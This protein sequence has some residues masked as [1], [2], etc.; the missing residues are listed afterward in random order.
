MQSSRPTPKGVSIAREYFFYSLCHCVTY[1]HGL[2]SRNGFGFLMPGSNLLVCQPFTYSEILIFEKTRGN[3]CIPAKVHS[4]G[5]ITNDMFHFA[6]V[7]HGKPVPMV[8]L[9][10]RGIISRVGATHCQYMFSM[11]G[12]GVTHLL[13]G[14]VSVRGNKAF[15]HQMTSPKLKTINT[16][17]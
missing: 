13:R 11:H 5:I 9:P 15:S 10:C 8:D 1:Y 4:L 17:G 2:F 3:R 14:G 16:L 7:V 12:Q 6:H